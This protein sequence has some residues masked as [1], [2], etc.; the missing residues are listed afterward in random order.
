MVA[1]DGI[2]AQIKGEYGAEQ[3]DAVDDPLAAV[4]EV[5]T[6]GRIGATQIGPAYTP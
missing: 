3:F 2:G 4:F 5:I 6:G 1:H